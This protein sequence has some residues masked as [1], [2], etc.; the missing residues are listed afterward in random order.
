MAYLSNNRGHVRLGTIGTP[1]SCLFRTC[2][3]MLI[4]VL[5]VNIFF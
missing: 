4:N 2:L 3:V 5:I 1:M